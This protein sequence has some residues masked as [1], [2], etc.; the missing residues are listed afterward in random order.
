MSG[1]VGVA[2]VASS[3]VLV[4]GAGGEWDAEADG[5]DEE[6]KQRD[7]HVLGPMSWHHAERGMTT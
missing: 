1:G 5:A 2:G 6:G 7:A 4:V 3:G